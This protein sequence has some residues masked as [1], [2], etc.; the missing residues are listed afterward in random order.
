M[1]CVQNIFL[2]ASLERKF[3]L[4][5][6]NSVKINVVNS[7]HCGTKQRKYRNETIPQCKRESREVPRAAS[8]ASASL[9]RG[10]DFPVASKDRSVKGAVPGQED[11][12]DRGQGRGNATTRTG[13]RKKKET[14]H[15]STPR[16]GKRQWC[17]GRSEHIAPSYAWQ[18]DVKASVFKS[19]ADHSNLPL[20]GCRAFVLDGTKLFHDKTQ[21][22]TALRDAMRVRTPELQR[23]GKRKSLAK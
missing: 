11:G 16:G 8:C 22:R 10:K 13:K 7:K 23:N 5:H 21:G 19:L 1:Q 17:L 9:Q 6:P 18:N 12:K 4:G 20:I 2:S 15:P 14:A 3:L